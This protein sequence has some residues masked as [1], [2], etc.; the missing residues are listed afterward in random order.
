[1]VQTSKTIEDKL[2]QVIVLLGKLVSQER[3]NRRPSRLMRLK[4]AASYI[5]VSPWKMRG[6]VQSGEIP[7]VKNNDGASG[8]VWLLD[9][10]DLDEWIDR[11]K[12]TL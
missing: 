9:V 5:C 11:T 6:L 1:M 8:G 3:T 7:V 4:D 10:R 2:D 12:V